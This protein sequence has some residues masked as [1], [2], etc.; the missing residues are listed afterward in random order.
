MFVLGQPRKYFCFPL[1]D[2]VLPEWVSRLET[3]FF[4]IKISN[5]IPIKLNCIQYNLS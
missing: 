1:P 5:W 3:Y 2:P 4:K